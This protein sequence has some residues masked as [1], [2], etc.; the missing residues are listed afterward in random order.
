MV[1]RD[2]L[3]RL[4][5]NWSRKI[6]D[7]HRVTVVDDV[8]RVEHLLGDQLG[9]DPAVRRRLR[10]AIRGEIPTFRRHEDLVPLN[11]PMIDG[12]SETPTDR[13]L[14]PLI[15][16]VDRRIENVDPAGLQAELGRLLHRFVGESVR[17]ADV[18]P[19]PHRRE[20][21]T[22]RRRPEVRRRNFVVLDRP[23]NKPAGACGVAAPDNRDTVLCS[24]GGSKALP[25]TRDPR[26]STMR[27]S[28]P[29][30]ARERSPCHVG[31]YGRLQKPIPPV[32]P[33]HCRYCRLKRPCPAHGP[34]VSSARRPVQ[35]FSSNRSLS[36]IAVNPARS[37]ACASSPGG[38]G[39]VVRTLSALT[40]RNQLSTALKSSVATGGLA[41]S[42]STHGPRNPIGA[43]GRCVPPA[44][45]RR[46][47]R[48]PAIQIVRCKSHA[49]SR[50]QLPRSWRKATGIGGGGVSGC[51][52]PKRDCAGATSP[53][54]NSRTAARTAE[55]VGRGLRS[56]SK[57]A[58]CHRTRPAGW[59]TARR[60][61][62]PVGDVD[63]EPPS[64]LVPK[65]LP[66]GA[67]QGRK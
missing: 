14:G 48:G 47:W 66:G 33:E 51:L 50:N 39:T 11:G 52:R 32:K 23:L 42:D 1:S 19:Q 7:A 13:P 30:S 31:R 17:R 37:S 65:P 59:A 5:S 36:A 2:R 55:T 8:G 15:P 45:P 62:T 28:T 26:G 41:A 58:R 44:T 43:R 38:V 67:E 6:R 64:L 10:L 60:S 46:S 27:S 20:M 56:R 29:R 61:G 34:P 18:G 4:R 9:L 12:P 3:T 22:P 57:T 49:G 35:T 21:Q 54:L 25:D 53:R 24:R 40:P 63:H 16:V